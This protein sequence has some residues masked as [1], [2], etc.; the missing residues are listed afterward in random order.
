MQDSQSSPALEVWQ[1]LLRSVFENEKLV[2]GFGPLS[3]VF[4]LFGKAVAVFDCRG[5]EATAIMCRD[6]LEGASYIFTHRQRKR[7]KGGGTSWMIIEP[8]RGDDG[9]FKIEPLSRHMKQTMAVLSPDQRD[10]FERIKKDGDSMAHFIE[11]QEHRL[12]EFSAQLAQNSHDERPSSN[13]MLWMKEEDALADLRDTASILLTLSR[14][15]DRQE[16]S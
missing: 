15:L 6:V 10:V 4:G 2:E 8:K 12:L 13:A 7:M 16:A 9:S 14:A 1:E 5:Y 3:F 11:N